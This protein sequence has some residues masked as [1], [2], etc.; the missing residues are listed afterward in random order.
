MSFE[1]RTCSKRNGEN[2]APK[3]PRRHGCRFVNASGYSYFPTVLIPT[4]DCLPAD[5]DGIETENNY[6][7]TDYASLARRKYYFADRFNNVE[8]AY[9]VRSMLINIDDVKCKK[10]FNCWI[11]L[12]VLYLFSVVI[13]LVFYERK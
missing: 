6:A 4:W 8:M 7:R 10:I 2:A 3:W 5:F 9:I 12:I 13:I 11:V 1:E